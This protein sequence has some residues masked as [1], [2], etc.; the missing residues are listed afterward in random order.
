VD[1]DLALSMP[2]KLTANTGMDALTH[3]IEAYLSTAHSEFTDGL[4][5][6]SIKLTTT[7]LEASFRSDPL[8]REMM[9]ESQ[10]MAGM[11]FSNA[12]LGIVHSMAHKTGAAFSGGHIVHGA[13]NAMYLPKVIKFNSRNYEAAER[14]REIA[15]EIG[16]PAYSP[17]QGVKSLIEKI[18]EM[19]KKMNIALSIKTYEG[20][21]IDE[22]EFLQKL[23]EVAKN[24]IG[25]ACTPSNPRQPTQ[26]EMEKLLKCC[27]YDTEVDF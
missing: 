26:E 3:A 25:D 4:A 20:G 9:H 27:F 24:A 1:A 10:C 14:Y 8:A 7:W 17:M 23:P 12:L 19:D 18:V 11:A 2:P 6:H 13:A 15:A 22:K 5:L 16:L 21:I